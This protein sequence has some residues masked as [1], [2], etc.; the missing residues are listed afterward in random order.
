MSSK[1]LASALFVSGSLLAAGVATAATTVTLNPSGANNGA[2]SADPAFGTVGLQANLYTTL[3]I[4]SNSGS[5]VPFTE[6]GLIDVTS[7]Q[8]SSA[9]PVVSG[10]GVNYKIKGSFTFSGTG[11]W[12]GSQYTAD[13]GG[14][15]L[16]SLDAYTMGDVLIKNLGSSTIVPGPSL[17]FAIAFGSVAAGSSGAALTSLTA[18][19]DLTPAAGETG[20]GGFF[21]APVPFYIDLAVGNA[22]GNP[23]NTGYSVSAGGVVT[24]INPTPGENAGTANVTFQSRVPEP[25]MLSLA[26]IALL[27]L[28]AFSRR[29]GRVEV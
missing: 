22:G 8:D 6:T 10:V 14:S 24:F 28:A 4:D 25:G 26:G 12:T 9:N 27:G 5:D 3:V 2:I 1:F 18:L 19:L 13:P 15:F 17:A 16:M 29:K 7:F 11:D 20:P 23:L 21:E